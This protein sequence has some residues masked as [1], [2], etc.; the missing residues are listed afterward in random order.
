[1]G[2]GIGLRNIQ[3]RLKALYD[4]RFTFDTENM[5]PQGFAITITLPAVLSVSSSGRKVAV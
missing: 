3:E 2:R 5:D 4:D 1:M